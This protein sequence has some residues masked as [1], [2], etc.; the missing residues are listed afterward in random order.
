MLKRDENVVC[1]HTYTQTTQPQ[2]E[3]TLKNKVLDQ[4]GKEKASRT[5]APML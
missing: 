5:A 1:A 2:Y 3:P 4:I